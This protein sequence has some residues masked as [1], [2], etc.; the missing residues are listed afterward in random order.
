MASSIDKKLSSTESTLK[1]NANKFEK[2]VVSHVNQFT[3]ST[4]TKVKALENHFAYLNQSF[5]VNRQSNTDNLNSIIN[6]LDSFNSV[7]GGLSKGLSNTQ[8]EVSLLRSNVP[9]PTFQPSTPSNIAPLNDP[10][11]LNISGFQVPP[12][13]PV[14]NY[15][16]IGS[17]PVQQM[18]SE[19]I[20]PSSLPVQEA[21]LGLIQSG[22]TQNQDPPPIQQIR[23]ESVRPDLTQ[24]QNAHSVPVARGEN[25]SIEEL[26]GVLRQLLTKAE[27][28]NQ[29]T[30]IEKILK[31][32]PPNNK[33][34][35]K[36]END[37]TKRSDQTNEKER[38][39]SKKRKNEHDSDSDRSLSPLPPKLPVF[40]GEPKTT[41]WQS[42]IAKFDRIAKRK[43]WSDGK[44]LYRLFDCLTEKALEYA[45]RAEEK[46]D[47]NKLKKELGLRFNIKDA[48]VADRSNLACVKQNEDESLEDF[49]HRVL[50]IAMNGFESADNN[51][52]QKLATEAFLRGCK[53]KEAAALALNQ[54]PSS[55]Q[56]ACRAVK[57]I[58]A[59]KKAIFGSKVSFQERYFTA[60]EE[61]RVS[62]TEKR[63]F[64]VEKTL[65]ISSPSPV[66]RDSPYPSPQRYPNNNWSPRSPTRDN[67]NQYRG[68]PR[69]RDNRDYQY[70]RDNYRSSNSPS[71][72]RNFQPRY[73]SPS[74]SYSPSNGRYP[75]GQ[76]P[77]QQQ[78]NSYRGD[79]RAPR[80]YRDRNY[81]SPSNGNYQNRNSPTNYSSSNGNYQS[82][83]SPTNAYIPE[84]P[85]PQRQSRYDRENP[86]RNHNEN[87]NKT[88]I[89]RC[90]RSPCGHSGYSEGEM[91][92]NNDLNS[93]G[94]AK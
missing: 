8:T 92:Q 9:P 68:R 13:T 74:R 87:P 65:G 15:N 34:V 40:S 45:E 23:Y 28:N 57:T 39:R 4:N 33:Y 84:N 42:F 76:S 93:D 73:Q 55:I 18:K 70:R 83:N 12:I 47:Y 71:G 63:L 85:S 75:R 80:D 2:E 17:F 46:D 32:I 36:A 69:T 90:S 1:D 44:K 37:Q 5:S 14:T 41:S 88:Q 29:E 20:P 54:C 82:R 19:F 58:M 61:E 77:Y 31:A 49:L 91:P 48:P 64:N 38:G 3:E 16:H 24:N 35:A 30:G 60:Q 43:K 21:R 53:Y 7:L 51:T 27:G 62:S 66:R 26:T 67:E 94:L 78:F 79:N 72:N 22:Q 56:E 59:N 86:N 10:A 81:S 6:K 25:S 50:T 52:M 11:I 89:R